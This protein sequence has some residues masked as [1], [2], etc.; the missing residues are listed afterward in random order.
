L[1]A[2]A[3][4]AAVAATTAPRSTGSRIAIVAGA[5]L[6]MGGGFAA[7]YFST[8]SLFLKPLTAEFGWGRAETAASTALA[9]VGLAFGSLVVGRLVDRFG[10]L[11][12]IAISAAAMAAL[13]ASLATLSGH[14]LVL[15]LLSF[16]IG[17]VGVGT[18]P[19]GYLPVLA[20][21]FDRRLGLALGS[22]MVGLGAGAVVMPLVGQRLIADHGWRGAYVG[23]AACSL[24]MAALAMMLLRLGAE[25]GPSMRMPAGDAAA[26]GDTFREAARTPRFWA[27]VA[28]LFVVSA[29]GLGA[30]VHI[31]ALL[32]DRGLS[33]AQ[34]AQIVALTG[35]GMTLGRLVAGALLDLVPARWLGAIAFALGG[36]GLATL[37]SGATTSLAALATGALLTGFAIG[38]EGD[39]IPYC[40]RRYFGV[41]AFGAIFGAL[42]GV[43]ALGGVAGPVAFGLAFDRLGSYGAVYAAA[44]AA[45]MCAAVFTAGLGRYRFASR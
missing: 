8:L 5:G 14:P 35:A 1:N 3:S 16:A 45:C 20:R 22:A 15:A 24:A 39:F 43:Y 23:L 33:A 10:A 41:R 11:R 9:M 6:G 21:G 29:A 2:I 36:V 13:I 7:S 25:T 38:A 28:I 34:A 26:E 30:G 32:T 19:A 40:V 27:L 42:F 4:T 31:A 44:A 17:L 12:V 37:A 18:T